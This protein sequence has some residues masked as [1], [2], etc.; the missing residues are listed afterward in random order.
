MIATRQTSIPARTFASRHRPLPWRNRAGKP[1]RRGNS[2]RY[3]GNVVGTSNA[4]GYFVE[5]VNTDAFGNPLASTQTGEWAGGLGGNRGLTTKELD[6]AAGMYYFYQRWYDPQTATFASRAPY[7]PMAEHPYGFVENT[8]IM[9]ID[10]LGLLSV[11]IIGTADDSEYRRWATAVGRVELRAGNDHWA[12][13]RVRTVAEFDAAVHELN[14]TIDQIDTLY[15]VSHGVR[16]GGQILIPQCETDD[17]SRRDLF[18]WDDGSPVPP[19]CG[20]INAGTTVVFNVCNL[21]SSERNWRNIIG[22]GWHE[23]FGGARVEANT[24]LIQQRDFST[25]RWFRG[26]WYRPPGQW[27]AYP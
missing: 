14:R 24:G 25:N 8:P 7:P 1:R 9:R 13:R 12:I 19:D 16:G 6:P 2:Y 4:S 15:I 3:I 27:F 18:V 20:G 11:W 22:P 21:A 5:A 26:W 23:Y 10:V 17:T